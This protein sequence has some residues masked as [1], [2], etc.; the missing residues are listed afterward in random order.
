MPIS[1]LAHYSIRTIDMEASRRFYTEVLGFK[2]GYRPPFKF[3]GIW[4]YLSDD[5]EE[6]GTLH[7]IGIDP[8]DPQGLIDYLGDKSPDSLKGS[9]A[10]DHIAFNA[11]GLAE[12]RAT[13][14]ARG[15]ECRERTVP[16]LRL[17]QVFVA[18]PSGIVIELNYPAAEAKG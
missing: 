2:V 10:L 12:M 6:Y 14:K 15:I 4:L 18:D 1:K 11:I 8:D 13:L 9:G 17:H 5:K 3:P 7:I 16:D